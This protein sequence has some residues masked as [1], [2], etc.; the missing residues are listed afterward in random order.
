MREL[1]ADLF[2]SW[3]HSYE[4]DHDDVMVHRSADHPFPPARGRRGMEFVPDGT[5]LDHPVGRGDAPDTVRGRWRQVGDRRVEVSFEDGRAGR[6]LE[7]VRC[8]A[9]VLEVRTPAA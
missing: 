7:I 9:D 8:D 5:F 4:E 1:P 6:V 3:L 2:R